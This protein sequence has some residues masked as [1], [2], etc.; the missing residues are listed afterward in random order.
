MR[1]DSYLVARVS[2]RLECDYRGRLADTI[3]D[4]VAED[5]RGP[6]PR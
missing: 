3:V 6:I 5:F 2:D 1:G 4:A